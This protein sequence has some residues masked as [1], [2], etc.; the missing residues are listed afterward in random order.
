[1]VA[2][3]CQV[4]RSEYIAKSQYPALTKA[5]YDAK[6]DLDSVRSNRIV[7]D[8]YMIDY[9]GAAAPNI[10]YA[11]NEYLSR[12][13]SSNDKIAKVFIANKSQSTYCKD[14]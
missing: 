10:D 11:V 13:N 9:F 3:S 6:I 7:I 8:W 1:M 14:V 12:Y 2:L 4:H 5:F